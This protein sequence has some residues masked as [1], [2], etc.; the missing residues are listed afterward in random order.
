M[1]IILEGCDCSGKTTLAENLAK[2]FDA[3]II[4]C[5]QNTQ[6]DFFYFYDIFEKSK[7]CNIIA[8]RFCYGQF[9]Y[10]QEKDRPL[11]SDEKSAAYNL[12]QLEYDML[13]SGS[14]KVVYVTARISTIKNRLEHRSE[15]LIN[16]LSVEEVLCRYKQVFQDSLM[17]VITW[18]T[19]IEEENDE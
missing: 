5:S 1:L 4:H 12:L 18:N 3:E 8:D 6:N 7:K 15:E 2:V 11:R 16:G 19:D 9:V 17:P 14:V 13:R 10:Q